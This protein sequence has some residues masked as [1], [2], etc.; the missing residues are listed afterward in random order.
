LELGAG[1]THFLR[2]SDRFVS[3]T[4]GYR[5]QGLNGLISRVTP[6]Y[7]YNSAMGGDSGF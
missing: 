1:Y 4:T 3:I 5:F 7:I 6:M 2:A